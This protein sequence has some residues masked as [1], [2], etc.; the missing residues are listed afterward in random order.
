[1]SWLLMA[2]FFIV[3]KVARLSSG[4]GELVKSGRPSANGMVDM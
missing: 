1:M 2:F 3:M 4:R